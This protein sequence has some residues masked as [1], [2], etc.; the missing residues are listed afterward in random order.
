MNG[1]TT[2]VQSDS[3]DRFITA[4]GIRI[5]INRLPKA[6]LLVY[7]HV[8][9]YDHTTLVVS[10]AVRAWSNGVRLGDFRASSVVFIP[11]G[12]VHHFE[13]LLDDTVFY[14]LHNVERSAGHIL[15]H[16]PS[17]TQ[18]LPCL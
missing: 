3:K 13:S 9:E 1:A 4:D 11:A 12:A 15:S 16:P 18:S 8:H 7:Q 14:C 5:E 2:C 17:A 10:G 6:G